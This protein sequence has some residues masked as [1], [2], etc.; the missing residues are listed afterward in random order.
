MKRFIVLFASVAL[1][2]GC[3]SH[4]SCKVAS[5]PSHTDVEL[6][7]DY[8][9]LVAGICGLKFTFGGRIAYTLRLPG[10]K[11]EYRGEEVRDHPI[12]PDVPRYGGNLSI[13][14]DTK[15]V[16]VKLTKYGAPFEM[17]GTYRYH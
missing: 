10:Q 14:R 9:G 2:S 13:F 5:V 7:K 11:S 4:R 16:V 6:R 12:L 8:Y 15:C 1:F 3:V 17:N